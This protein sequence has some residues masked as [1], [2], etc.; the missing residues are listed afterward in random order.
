MGFIILLSCIFENIPNK[1][2]LVLSPRRSYQRWERPSRE[3]SDG[4]PKIENVKQKGDKCPQSH[5]GWGLFHLIIHLEEVIPDSEHCQMAGRVKPN[6][7][8]L[9]WR[10]S[11][12][13]VAPWIE[14]RRRE[15]FLVAINW[16]RSSNKLVL[17][18]LGINISIPSFLF[19]H[20]H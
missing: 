1:N 5:G 4:E 9:N 14:V 11:V 20:D 16:N 13:S 3:G 2:L 19:G 17:N 10:K 8:V 6:T 12:Q 7:W 18:K 15:N